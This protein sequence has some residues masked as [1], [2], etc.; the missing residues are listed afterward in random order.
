MS[1]AAVGRSTTGAQPLPAGGMRAASPRDLQRRNEALRCLRD[2]N[3]TQCQGKIHINIFFDGTGNN[4]EWAGTFDS[5]HS[6]STQTQLKRNSQ[7]NVS[8]L[9]HAAIEDLDAGLFN[10]YSPGVGTPF[11]EV[12]D[13][14]QEGEHPRGC[15]R[16]IWSPPHQLGDPAGL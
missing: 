5:V 7:S 9:S 3:P 16:Q 6:R 1:N 14:N 8:R 10:Y 15:I 13:T 11:E 4:E 12:G 2:E